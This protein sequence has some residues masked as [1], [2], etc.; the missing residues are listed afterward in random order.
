M[1]SPGRGSRAD[2][3]THWRFYT[4]WLA[5][6]HLSDFLCMSWRRWLVRGR[7]GFLSLDS[8]PLIPDSDEQQKTDGWMDLEKSGFAKSL[9]AIAILSSKNGTILQAASTVSLLHD[10]CVLPPKS[11]DAVF[12]CLCSELTFDLLDVKCHFVL[13]SQSV[14]VKF[15]CCYLYKKYIL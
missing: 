12:I 6:E 8:C 15:R 13:H 7:S 4:P 3:G 5:W 1:T 10:G 2:L 14:S 9:P 11:Q